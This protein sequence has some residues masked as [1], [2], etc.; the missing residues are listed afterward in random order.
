MAKDAPSQSDRRKELRV[1]LSFPVRYSF[2]CATGNGRDTIKGQ[3]KAICVSST[4]ICL[5]LDTP[6]VLLHGAP[7]NLT[8]CLPKRDFTVLA[9]GWLRWSEA[10]DGG[11][12]TGALI[13]V[14]EKKRKF[15]QSIYGGSGAKKRSK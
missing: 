8:L 1:S 12:R 15:R 4:G 7:M 5:Q 14:T 2:K 3:G 13:D 9:K 11:A 6:S 10:F